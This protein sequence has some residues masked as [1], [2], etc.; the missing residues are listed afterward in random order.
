MIVEVRHALRAAAEA[1][2][3]ASIAHEVAGA[4][5]ALHELPRRQIHECI[6][7][8]CPADRWVTLKA[9]AK[10]AGYSYSA[11]FREAVNQLVVRGEL[12]RSKSGVRKVR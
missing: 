5:P 1:L 8:A 12:V 10:L 2:A 4:R 7:E 3:V 6:L 9:L 11:Y